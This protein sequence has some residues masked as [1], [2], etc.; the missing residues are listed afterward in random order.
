MAVAVETRPDVGTAVAVAA[1]LLG[2]AL[3]VLA[4][5]RLSTTESETR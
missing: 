3:T 4:C 5:A 1:I 2:A